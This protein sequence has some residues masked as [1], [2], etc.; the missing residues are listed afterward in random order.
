MSLV[1]VGIGLRP[2]MASPLDSRAVGP[3]D[4]ALY[5][6]AGLI[7]YDPDDKELYVYRSAPGVQGWQS[8]RNYLLTDIF[9]NKIEVGTSGRIT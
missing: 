1:D 2:L 4:R 6:Y 8:L 9:N 3:L 7:R 5:P